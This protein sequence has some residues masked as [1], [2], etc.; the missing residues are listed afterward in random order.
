MGI[1]ETLEKKIATLEE[2]IKNLEIVNSTLEASNKVIRANN[3]ILFEERNEYMEIVENQRTEIKE[4]TG[5]K[6]HV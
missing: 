5:D 1:I 4:L 2:I 6:K 3:R